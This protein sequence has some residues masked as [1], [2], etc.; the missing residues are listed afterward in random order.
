VLWHDPQSNGQPVATTNHA[1]L[2]DREGR[3]LATLEQV[4]KE[5][6][7]RAYLDIELKAAGNEPAVVGALKETPPQREFIVSSFYPDILRRLH[8]LDAELPL[9]FICD[10][11]DAFAIWREMAVRVFLPEH[12]FVTRALINEVHSRGWQIMTWTVNRR[13]DMLRL[14]EWG[15][16]GLIS[17]DPQLLY[18]T[19]HTT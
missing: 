2:V 6:A 1:E 17:D 4:V 14:A 5:F 16:D 3:R 12:K 15:I 8:E 10:R 11:D 7:N 9:G 13:D 19:F 18:Q